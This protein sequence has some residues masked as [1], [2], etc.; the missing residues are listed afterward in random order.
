M[1]NGLRW[2]P[3]LPNR[4]SIGVRGCRVRTTAVTAIPTGSFTEL[5]F[6]EIVWASDPGMWTPA[7]PNR[8]YIPPTWGRIA[9]AFGNSL[10]DPAMIEVG[11]CVSGTDTGGE[12]YCQ[13]VPG[14]EPGYMQFPQNAVVCDTPRS[15]CGVNWSPISLL[16]TNQ[17]ARLRV[18]H[19]YG[20]NKNFGPVASANVPPT[21]FWLRWIY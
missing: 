1:Q 20:V 10:A 14:I 16:N 13:V 2:M 5:A 19:D 7:N 18:H 6:G 17:Y 3:R 8:I 15:R 4:A 11:Y 21:D 9:Q 12:A